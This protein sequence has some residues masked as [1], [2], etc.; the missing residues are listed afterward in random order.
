MVKDRRLDFQINKRTQIQIRDKPMFRTEDLKLT[1]K[2]MKY[3]KPRVM[4]QYKL[5]RANTVEIKL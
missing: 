2:T 5:G 1:D 4:W 3:E